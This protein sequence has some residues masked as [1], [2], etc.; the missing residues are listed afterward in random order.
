MP[1]LLLQAGG[2]RALLRPVAGGRVCELVLESP[3]GAPVPVLFPYT[4][5]DV[6]PLRWA[7]GGIYPLAPYSNRIAGAR[8]QTPQGEIALDPHPDARPHTLHGN[9]HGLAWGVASHTPSSAT[10]ALDS[11]ACGAWPW[12]YRAT[13][14][15]ELSASA[16]DLVLEITNADARPMPAGLGWHP[17]LRH[18]PSARLGFHATTSWPETPD[19]L[20]THA[21]A[22]RAYEGYDPPRPLRPGTLT[23]YLSGWAGPLSVELS[24]GVTLWMQPGE[25]LS[26]LVLHRPPDGRYL[27]IEPVTH[28]ADGFNLDAR[29]VPGTGTRWLQPG[30]VLTA[31]LQMTLQPPV[32][33]E[34][35]A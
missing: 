35:S 32:T 33:T 2:A 3:T 21:R 19:F 15:V 6:D 22:L 10:V 25:G 11:P 31:T 14:R 18:V 28:V 30:Q 26:H 23:D 24:E 20:A 4:E 9:A 34:P 13:Q 27:C 7:K 17:Y 5:P 12:H 16:L 8:L 29:G 1:D